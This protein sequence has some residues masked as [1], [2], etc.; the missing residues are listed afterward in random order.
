LRIYQKIL[1]K[2]GLVLLLLLNACGSSPLPTFAPIPSPTLPPSP[3][4]TATSLPG[5]LKPAPTVQNLPTYAID[6]N[7]NASGDMVINGIKRTFFFHLPKGFDKN[8]TYPLV[9]NFHGAGGQGA[10]WA[11]SSQFNSL[12]DQAGFIVVYPDALPRD[13]T[14]VPP[15]TPLPTDEFAWLRYYDPSN[16]DVLFVRTLFIYFENTYKID[17]RRIYATGFS[18]GGFFSFTLGC[19]LADKFAAIHLR[20]AYATC[21]PTSPLSVLIINGTGDNVVPVAGTRLS[22]PANEGR[23]FWLKANNCQN[24]EQKFN[25]VDKGGVKSSVLFWQSC[26]NNVAVA[27]YLVEGK[28]HEWVGDSDSNL[29]PCNLAKGDCAGHNLSYN[30]E[31]W[32]FFAAHPKS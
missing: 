7:G 19:T 18:S 12:A 9:L 21:K 3:S 15:S 8:K 22:F 24:N 27:Q 25:I 1:A 23:D 5:N 28:G 11:S 17:L 4:P 2:I 6:N 29:T 16:P 26:Q 13:N 14:T 30:R 20:D 10:G 32:A 31:I